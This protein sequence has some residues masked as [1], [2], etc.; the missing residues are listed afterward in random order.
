MRDK[1][2]KTVH[3]ITQNIGECCNFAV[4]RSTSKGE[5]QISNHANERIQI[6]YHEWDS[7]YI[8]GKKII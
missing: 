1:C 3:L 4:I 6:S 7:G 2:C 5:P 8:T